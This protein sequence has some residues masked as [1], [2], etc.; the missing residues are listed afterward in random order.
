M[1]ARTGGGSLPA[2]RHAD[3]GQGGHPAVL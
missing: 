2:L 3:D 1:E